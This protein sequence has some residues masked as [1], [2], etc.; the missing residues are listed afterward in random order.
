MA[1]S[2]AACVDGFHLLLSWV[3]RLFRLNRLKLYLVLMCRI[4]FWAAA[5]FA[6]FQI[7]MDPHGRP[8]RA[9]PRTARTITPW[10]FGSISW[11]PVLCLQLA[12][13]RP[14]TR[15]SRALSGSRDPMFDQ[16]RRS[17]RP[18]AIASITAGSS[19]PQSTRDPCIETLLGGWPRLGRLPDSDADRV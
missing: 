7:G 3:G 6:E 10:Q 13:G 8:A 11:L 4:R 12:R 2:S 9:H 5:V 14:G 15:P 1:C 16:C 18:Y 19:P 17:R